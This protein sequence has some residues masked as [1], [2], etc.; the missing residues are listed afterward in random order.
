MT[1][2][3]TPRPDVRP[4]TPD[5]VAATVRGLSARMLDGLA[6][7]ATGY[8]GTGVPT[9]RALTRRGLL[10]TTDVE[11]HPYAA[12]TL[13]GLRVLYAVGRW[14]VDPDT[15][16]DAYPA[17]ALVESVPDGASVR[18]TVAAH[19]S[20]V[21]GRVRVDWHGGNSQ[22]VDPAHIRRVVEPTDVEPADPWADALDGDPAPV[23]LAPVPAP[24]G[25]AALDVEPRGWRLIPR[26]RAFTCTACGTDTLY[27]GGMQTVNGV[28]MLCNRCDAARIDAYWHARPAGRSAVRMTD[29]DGSSTVGGVFTHAPYPYPDDVPPSV[30]W[31]LIASAS[32]GGGHQISRT[33]RLITQRVMETFREVYGLP[34]SA[35]GPEIIAAREADPRDID[36]RARDYLCAYAGQLIGRDDVEPVERL[37]LAY[38]T[39]DAEQAATGVRPAVGT[40]VTLD[41]QPGAW[42]VI[43]RSELEARRFPFSMRVQQPGHPLNGSVTLRAVVMPPACG[44]CDAAPGAAC[45]PTCGSSEPA[46]SGAELVAHARDGVAAFQAAH[47]A[48]LADM[49]AEHTAADRWTA[50]VDAAGDWRENVGRARGKI[51]D[52]VALALREVYGLPH[53]IARQDYRDA[54]DRANGADTRDPDTRAR[55]YLTAYAGAIHG[56]DMVE[57]VEALARPYTTSDADQVAAG[58]RPAVGTLVTVT[59]VPGTQDR[60]HVVERSADEQARSPFRVLVQRIGVQ[61]VDHVPHGSVTVYVDPPCPALGE[62][63][64]TAGCREAHP[65]GI[66]S[67]PAGGYVATPYNP[68]RDDWYPTP[69]AEI[70]QPHPDDFYG[71]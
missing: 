1:T 61:Y 6:D 31:G 45:L 64:H 12:A 3:T 53:P 62:R 42:R 65:A 47:V 51:G 28:E 35:D 69:G 2:T 46:P 15:L 50:I 48:Y 23:E 25:V 19:P 17:G 20:T 54:L 24:A 32:G 59:G 57:P 56:L 29:A 63:W 67:R 18:G 30:R 39:T 37:A 38:T 66:T 71:F 58:I 33:R 4:G 60:G 68:N 52:R 70:H 44:E 26:D 5:A 11:R 36:T 9:E 14:P 34:F 41:G 13:D 21:P 49:P 40:L 27:G 43:E 16:A 7:V 10:T 8:R 22:D 55:D